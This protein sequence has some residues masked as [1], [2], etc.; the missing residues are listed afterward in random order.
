MNA[1][2]RVFRRALSA[3]VVVF[4]VAS[5][6]FFLLATLP[7][8]PARMVSGPQAR[9]ED[10]V[11]IRKELQLDKPLVTRYG[12]FVKKL[13]HI[14]KSAGV[15]PH[16][17]C[18]SACTLPG[19]YELHFDLGRSY[20]HNTPVAREI[21]TRFPRSVV[22]AVAGIF[23]QLLFGVTLGSIA[24]AKKG[25]SVDR[26]IT[27]LSSLGMSAPTFLTAVLLQYLFAHRLR[28]LPLDG[29]GNTLPAH[30]RA[31]ILPALTLGFYGAAYFARL[32]RDEM[33]TLLGQD[34]VRT[35]RAKGASRLRAF[36]VHALRGALLPL[37]TAAGLELGALAS[38]AAVTESIFRWPGLGHLGVD[39]VLNRDGPMVMGVVLVAASSVVVATATID[40]LGV[41]LHPLLR[42]AAEELDK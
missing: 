1:I 36:V 26:F 37:A 17:N 42:T 11:R 3:V 10:L 39:A 41:W 32:V 20:Q 2:A 18:E 27:G 14:G 25:T 24:A 33:I 6:S 23:V 7:G 16:Q 8:D 40:I 5:V 15:V 4:A 9:P 35:A 28:W 34:F 29:F 21:A 22:L 38:G 12:E 31:I 19:A 30:A 13:V